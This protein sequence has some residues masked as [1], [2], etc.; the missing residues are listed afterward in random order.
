MIEPEEAHRRGQEGTSAPGCVA[1][2]EARALA[3][4]EEEATVAR[5]WAG[6][7]V[8]AVLLVF[9]ASVLLLEVDVHAT[10]APA[11]SCGSGW[12]VV[13]G[14]A[15]WP[16]WWAQDLADPA[17]GVGGPLVRTLHCP[18]AVNRRIVLAGGF[19][20]VAVLVVSVGEVSGRRGKR[21]VAPAS[22]GPGDRFRR[23]GAVTTAL[24]GLVTF[25]GLV[26][27]VLL[28]ANPRSTLFLYVDRP[29]VALVG[30]LLLLPAIVLIAL[31]RAATLVGRELAD[32]EPADEGT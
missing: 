28:V 24:G 10:A 23:L 9:A 30:L 29:V 1:E 22:S 27:V 2:L 15:G 6:K 20:V 32:P 12:D 14:R 17:G 11:R 5:N 7:T 25:A 8:G 16:E 26:G 13:A 3:A 4:P 31:G 19:A 18:G 21:S